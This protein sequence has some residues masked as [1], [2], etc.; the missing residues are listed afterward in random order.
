MEKIVKNF[1]ENAGFV[2][3]ETYFE[4]CCLQDLMIS[5]FKPSNL[6]SNLNQKEFDFILFYKDNLF[7]IECNFYQTHG[8]KINETIKNYEAIFNA[9]EKFK[10]FHFIW[11]TD[12]PGWE[13]S[14]NQLKNKLSL[15]NNMFNIYELENSPNGLLQLL[16]NLI[17]KD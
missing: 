17:M 3:N 6:N 11:I 1:I 10:K 13:K 16:D 9:F 5:K 14:K 8:S 2:K 15:I 4:Q 7:A 12:G